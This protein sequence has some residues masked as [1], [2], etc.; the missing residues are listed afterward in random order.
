MLD[1]ITSTEVDNYIS[2]LLNRPK[3]AVVVRRVD[4][5]KSEKIIVDRAKYNLLCKAYLEARGKYHK[6]RKKWE[7]YN[8]LS[9]S[10][11]LSVKAVKRPTCYEVVIE[12]LLSNGLHADKSHILIL[13]G[14]ILRDPVDY[15]AV[16]KTKIR[17]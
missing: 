11:K 10:E 5:E 15:E 9:S 17:Y 3:P 8:D 2:Q 13:G 7:I 1:D 4:T 6:A 14:I 12:A 16:I